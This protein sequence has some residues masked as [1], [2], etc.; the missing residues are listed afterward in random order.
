MNQLFIRLPLLCLVGIV[1]FGCTPAAKTEIDPGN[2]A[3]S[4]DINIAERRALGF[5]A[6]F[7]SGDGDQYEAYMQENRTADVLAAASAR[8]RRASFEQLRE[9]FGEFTLL[10]VL[11]PSM[12]ETRVLVRTAMN[13]E[14]E[15]IFQHQ[16]DDA[17]IGSISFEP[18]EQGVDVNPD[19]ENLDSLLTDYVEQSGVPAWSVAVVKGGKIIDQASVGRR[20]VTGSAPVSDG[21]R[22]HWGSVT[23]SVTG[24]MIGALI[25]QGLLDW[26][27]TIGDVFSD[28]PIR[29]EYR[30]ITIS[31]LMSHRAGIPP[32]EN[33]DR[34][35]IDRLQDQ[36][37]QDLRDQRKGFAL[38]VLKNDKPIFQ[39]GE[40]HRYSN[41]GITIAGVMAEIVTGQAWEELVRENVFKAANMNDARFGWPATNAEP[42]QTRGHFGSGP[43]DIDVAPFDAFENLLVVTAPAANV[44]STIG[45]FARY[46]SLHLQ[47][48]NGRDGA[49]KS[50]T[51]KRLHAPLPEELLR[52]EPYSFGWGQVKLDNGDVMHWHNGGAGSFYAEIRLIPEHDIAIVMM[53]NAGFGEMKIRP[54]WSA[55]YERY[56]AN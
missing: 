21:S 4:E 55:L 17:K 2:Q 5:V 54:L 42:N 3:A 38:G 23:K 10:G 37:G 48:M 6:A 35:F 46:A 12:A 33:F 30:A 24:T 28:Y 49:I 31:Q 11:Q 47:G 36:F 14:L 53:A 29:D 16:D 51:I 13:E 26:D 19:W 8:E 44:Q 56:V 50:E 15:I 20:S 27:T 41:G 18:V 39:P 22:F 9:S 32:Y 45:D 43:D 7:N 34:E 40:G 25:E 52:A 1:Y